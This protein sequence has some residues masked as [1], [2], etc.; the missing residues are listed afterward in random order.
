MTKKEILENIIDVCFKMEP[1]GID[2]IDNNIYIKD[3]ENNNYL[4]LQ[5][6]Q[7]KHILLLINKILL[8]LKRFKIFLNNMERKI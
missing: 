2:V 6:P 8:F 5:L 4:I 7:L 3:N 1:Q